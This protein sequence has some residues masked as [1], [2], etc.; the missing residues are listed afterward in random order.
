MTDSLSIVLTP[1]DGDQ[2]GLISRQDLYDV[3]D[4]ITDS[5]LSDHQKAKIVD[6][7]I[8]YRMRH[9]GCVVCHQ[10]TGLVLLPMVYLI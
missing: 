1:P 8:N 5:N 2:D 7:V 9:S 10:V 4:M 3:M 6:E